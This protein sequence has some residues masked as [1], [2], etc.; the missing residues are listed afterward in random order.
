MERKNWEGWRKY[1]HFFPPSRFME[2]LSKCDREDYIN[3]TVRGELPIC[4]R[5]WITA[6]S[7]SLPLLSLMCHLIQ[8]PLI[9]SID[10]GER[11]WWWVFYANC[12]ARWLIYNGFLCNW[13]QQDPTKGRKLACSPGRA[14]AAGLVGGLYNTERYLHGIETKDP[15]P[16]LNG[17]FSWGFYPLLSRF[18]IFIARGSAMFWIYRNR[19]AIKSFI[20][21]LYPALAYPLSVKTFI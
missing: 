1:F 20:D 18:Y 5:C 9:H 3:Y 15:P 17:P 19:L 11:K 14:R 12:A 8:L 2:L 16:V 6:F 21:A 13:R 4:H 10:R 7:P